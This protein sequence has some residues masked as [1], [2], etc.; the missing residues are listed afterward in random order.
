M[1]EETFGDLLPKIKP[2]AYKILDEFI[3]MSENE[4]PLGDVISKYTNQNNL[5]QSQGYQ[6]IQKTPFLKLFSF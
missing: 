2:S 1:F 6:S 3:I 4:T 5:A